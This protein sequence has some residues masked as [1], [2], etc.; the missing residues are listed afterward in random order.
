[1]TFVSL[2]TDKSP[3]WWALSLFAL[4]LA[5]PILYKL[6]QRCGHGEM[7]PLVGFF[8]A[9]SFGELFELVGLKAH[10]GAIVIGALLSGHDKAAELSKSLLSFKDVFLIGFF[11]S[12]GFTALPQIRLRQG[13]WKTLV[14]IESNHLEELV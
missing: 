8:F 13:D 10:L 12:I 1:M 6:L 11:L 5:R 7:L 9:L 2:A 3:S 14:T 4:P